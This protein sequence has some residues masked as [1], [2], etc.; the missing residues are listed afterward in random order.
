MQNYV[1]NKG[2]LKLTQ[3]FFIDNANPISILV[4]PDTVNAARSAIVAKMRR[5]N[6]IAVM[7]C[8]DTHTGRVFYVQRR[9]CFVLRRTR[10]ATL[11]QE[12]LNG[13]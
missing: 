7:L 12:W 11:K 3:S 2:N 10:R 5:I 8:W 13:A 6:V 1:N 4:L 9:A